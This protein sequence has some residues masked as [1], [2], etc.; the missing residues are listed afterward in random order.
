VGGA[1]EKAGLAMV[2]AMRAKKNATRR[3]V[4]VVFHDVSFQ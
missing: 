2:A 3:E 4:V 1:W